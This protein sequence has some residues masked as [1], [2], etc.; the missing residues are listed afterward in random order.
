M[1]ASDRW[2]IDSTLAHG[3]AKADVDFTPVS[4]TVDWNDAGAPRGGPNVSGAQPSVRRRAYV[5]LRPL[6]SPTPG[7][8]SDDAPA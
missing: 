1:G 8:R 6:G 7:P 3:T 4:G 5:G 2:T